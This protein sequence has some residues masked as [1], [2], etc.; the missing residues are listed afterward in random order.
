MQALEEVSMK[1][2]AVRGKGMKV[3]KP[4]KDHVR[5]KMDKITGHYTDITSF[6]V[7]LTDEGENVNPEA[8]YS[9]SVTISLPK[10]TVY[11]EAVGEDLYATID[12]VAHKMNRAIVR[13]KEIKTTFRVPTSLHQHHRHMLQ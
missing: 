4:V 9:V 1:R 2:I 11:A 12:N 13:H 3:T 5:R 6:V 7:K 10:R 8:R